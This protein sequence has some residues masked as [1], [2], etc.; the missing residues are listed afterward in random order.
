MRTESICAEMRE[1]IDGVAAVAPRCLR[2][3]KSPA[4]RMP[5]VRLTTERLAE[6]TRRSP[7]WHVGRAIEDYVAV[8]SWQLERIEAG[9]MAADRR[10]FASDDEVARVRA[11]F[12]R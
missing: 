5:C 11:K 9:I 2:A 10:D 3:A 8:N 4:L 12:G 1:R 7:A 6:K